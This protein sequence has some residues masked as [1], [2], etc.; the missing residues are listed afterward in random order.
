MQSKV[1]YWVA[2]DGTIVRV[3]PYYSR[4]SADLDA[5][6]A[7]PFRAGELVGRNLFSF[8]AGSEVRHLYAL[9]QKR[10]LEESTP[11]SFDY[12]CDS[13]EVRRE[14]RMS[15]AADGDHVRYESAVLRETLRK[16]AIRPPTAGAESIVVICSM[17]NQFRFPE[18]SSDW[19]EL[20]ELPGE[21]E[22]PERFRFSHALCSSCFTRSMAEVQGWN[23]T[24]DDQARPKS[25]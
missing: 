2:R 14:M 9:L 18:A 17:C 21:V 10:V 6:F 23:S 24:P 4:E 5:T 3:E 7:N 12:R 13:L 22:L 19:K 11:I 1:V 15:M 20:D 8:I 16:K 25:M